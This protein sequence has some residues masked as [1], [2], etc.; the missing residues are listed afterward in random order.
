M[1]N[2][3]ALRKLTNA[4]YLQFLK[5]IVDK[6]DEANA[7]TLK[8][9]KG[10]DELA[11]LLP[12]LQNA[13]NNEIAS[14]ETKAIQ[15][16]D[17]KRD[18]AIVGLQTIVSGNTYHEDVT[19]KTAA[20]LLRTYFKS[21]GSKISKLNYQAETAVLDKVTAD[22]KTESRYIQAISLMGLDVWLTNLENANK[23][24]V[25]VFKSR[26]S[27]IS[28]NSTIL[29]FGEQKKIGIPVFNKMMA[30]IESRYNTAVEDGLP[31][32]PYQK[33]VNEINTLVASYN[34]YI[35]KPIKTSE[36]PQKP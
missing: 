36:E 1:F 30:L 33:L 12:G 9:K 5:L 24:F 6:I 26:N 23:L 25:I 2:T 29:S 22:L 13:L 18:D 31:T 14:A 21:H 10:R 17:E 28:A 7:T 35:S 11:N 3:I 15:D 27:E 16:L 4:L 34:N 19:I 20:E 32:E 8:L